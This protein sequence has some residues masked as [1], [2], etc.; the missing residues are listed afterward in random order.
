M[1]LLLTVLLA[2][3]PTSEVL[4]DGSVQVAIHVNM[5]PDAVRARMDSPTKIA[6]LTQAPGIESE[7]KEGEC[8]LVHHKRDLMIYSINWHTR[9]CPTELGLLETMIQGDGIEEYRAD[10]K[11]TP[12]GEGSLVQLQVTSVTALPVPL[13]LVQSTSIK[14]SKEGLVNLKAALEGKS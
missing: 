13:S 7:R 11:V 9:A 3:A 1:P 5:A 4:A 12:D 8:F 14:E 10:W 2:S 6:A